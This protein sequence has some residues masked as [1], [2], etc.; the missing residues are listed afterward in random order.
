M[1]QFN[2]LPDI[3]LDYLKASRYKKLV[4]AISILVSLVAIVVTGLLFGYTAVQGSQI[5]SLSADIK[6]Q[7]SKITNSN[8]NDLLT[9]QNQIGTLTSLHEQEPE[10]SRLS[11]Y[12]NQIIPT[13]AN[14]SNISVDFSANTISMTGSAD[15]LVTINKLVDS[16]KFASYTIK[17]QYGSQPAFSSVVLT[18][19]GIG[20]SQDPTASYSI[21]FSFDPNL[22]N[23]TET[24]NLTVPSKATTRSEIDQPSAL[25]KPNP[26]KQGTGS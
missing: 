3:K 23:N 6:N 4:T 16:L 17:G 11:T 10:V 7:G 22:F 12:L 20:T 1:T 26:P 24:V 9:I 18:S 8:I 19:F 21:S 5:K 2:L 25:F 13:T 14:I 15:S